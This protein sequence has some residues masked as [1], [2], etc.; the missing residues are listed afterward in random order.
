MFQVLRKEG[1]KERKIYSLEYS[2]KRAYENEDKLKLFSNK[3][4]LRAFTSVDPY[5]KKY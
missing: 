1:R 5:Y 2:A 3:H 4:K